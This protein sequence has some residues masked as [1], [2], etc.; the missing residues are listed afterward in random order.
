M[1][2]IMIMIMV[3]MMTAAAF[4]KEFNGRYWSGAEDSGKWVG[5]EFVEEVC[6]INDLNFSGMVADGREQI[7]TGRIQFIVNDFECPEPDEE[8]LARRGYFHCFVAYVNEHGNVAFVYEFEE[9][10]KLINKFCA[11]VE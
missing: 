9:G 1:K 6:T 5:N 11:K 8:V 10:G 4:A 2:K 7:E 3:V